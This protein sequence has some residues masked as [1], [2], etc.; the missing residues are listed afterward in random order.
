MI[1]VFPKK[2]FLVDDNDVLKIP[3]IS[4]IY[5]MK[6]KNIENLEIIKLDFGENAFEYLFDFPKIK[7]PKLTYDEKKINEIYKELLYLQIPQTSDDTI[8]MEDFYSDVREIVKQE[9]GIQVEQFFEQFLYVKLFGF[10]TSILHFDISYLCNNT[11]LPESFFEKHSSYLKSKNSFDSIFKHVSESFIEKYINVIEDSGWINIC[12]NDNVSETFF[13]KYIGQ[14]FWKD[15]CY[16]KNLSES[17]YIK[18]MDKIKSYYSNWSSGMIHF[19]EALCKNPN[20]SESFFEKYR[21]YINIFSLCENSNISE[22][23]FER[24]LETQDEFTRQ[25]IVS[26]LCYN[27]NISQKFFEKY[28]HD[29]N[30]PAMNYQVLCSNPNISET[31]IEEHFDITSEDFYPYY[32]FKNPNIS[33][34]FIRKVF[35]LGFNYVCRYSNMLESFFEEF[36]D[37]IEWKFLCKNIHISEGFFEKHIDKVVWSSLCCNPNISI[38]FFTK[39]YDS[40]KKYWL[41]WDNLCKNTFKIYNP[42][43]FITF[44]CE[45][46]EDDQMIISN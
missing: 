16:N 28:I 44:E 22:S 30:D 1:I 33:E 5:T 38:S 3:L 11:S 13:E 23:F 9:H 43:D 37:N 7:K 39:Y 45:D 10:N 41:T 8:D 34:T 18:H 25:S 20:L 14:V 36:M 4:E 15:I 21:D 2:V 6:R 46:V 40:W 12:M 32:I 42:F 19:W 26:Q 31:F 29:F 27:H 24:Y 35:P 17:F